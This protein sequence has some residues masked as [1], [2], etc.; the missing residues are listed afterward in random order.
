MFFALQHHDN[1]SFLVVFCRSI[2]SFLFKRYCFVALDHRI[3]DYGYGWITK[4]T[5][6]EVEVLNYCNICPESQ[7]IYIGY[8]ETLCSHEQVAS[9]FSCTIGYD[10]VRI[11][12]ALIRD[13]CLAACR[14]INEHS[15][16]LGD[17][18]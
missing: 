16:E 9:Q 12:C 11:H 5:D 6:E 13:D 10:R 8:D 18:R 15:L 3:H 4:P 7:R 1:H 14:E 17:A 2:L